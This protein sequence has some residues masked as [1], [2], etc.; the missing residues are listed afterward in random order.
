MSYFG[1]SNQDFKGLA[2]RLRIL[3]R[4]HGN[5]MAVLVDDA[6]T[7]ANPGQAIV[8]DEANP[9]SSTLTGVTKRG[10]LSGSVAF[11]R[12][13]TSG[14]VAVDNMVGGPRRRGGS[15]VAAANGEDDGDGDNAHAEDARTHV[16]GLFV[17]DAMG[18][19]NFDNQAGVASGKVAYLSGPVGTVGVQ[20]YETRQQIDWARGGA[21][22]AVSWGSGQY[23]YGSIN[24]LVTNLVRDALESYSTG[25]LNNAGNGIT[26]NAAGAVAAPSVT[27]MGTTKFGPTAALPE[28]CFDMR[29]FKYRTVA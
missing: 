20:V 22:A 28:V 4:G 12:P 25:V 2:G 7:Q 13:S 8:S 5:C 3:Y 17:N 9:T 23:V 14:N 29:L 15:S 11:T 27:I 24:G 21:G 6:Y 18:N 16:V 19:Q 1:I 10:V 26:D